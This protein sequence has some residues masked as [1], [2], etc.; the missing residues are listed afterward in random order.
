[1]KMKDHLLINVYV[2]TF[3]LALILFFPFGVDAAVSISEVAWMGSFNSANHE[4]IELH[5]DGEAI[6]VTGWSISDGMNLSIEFENDEEQ[7]VIPANSYVVLERTSDASALVNAFLIYTGALVNSGATLQ[8][9]RE[10]GSIVDQVS[11][12]ENWENIGGDNVTKE[13]AQYT[14]AGWVTATPTAGRGITTTEVSVAVTDEQTEKTTN[15]TTVSSLQKIKVDEPV[16]LTLPEVALKLEIKSQKVGYVHQSIQLLVEPSGIGDVLIDSLQYEWNFGDGNSSKGK[17]VAHI[18]NYPGTYVVTVY[19]GYKRQEQV[20]KTEITIL[21]VQI[22][23][24]MNTF[25]DVQVNNDSPYDIDISG[26]RINAEREFVFPPRTI[27]LSNQTI[28][29]P[30]KK[31]GDLKNQMI[32]IYDTESTM[33]FS[34]LPKSFDLLREEVIDLSPKPM[35]SAISHPPILSPQSGVSENFSFVNTVE[36]NSEDGGNKE[37][38]SEATPNET[39]EVSQLTNVGAESP[40]TNQYGTY[41][42]LIAFL[43]LAIVGVYATPRQ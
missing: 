35:I 13:T 26:Y 38:M 37:K 22:S 8:L 25:G 6:D 27:L 21:P 23:L 9:L 33:L 18:Y 30:Y 24:T 19:A 16:V 20:T 15:I 36:A 3:C 42:A 10:D 17:E 43:S 1:M 31:L 11:G 28:T 5:N 41:F 12:G 40:K 34:K 4:W 29:I 2:H 39:L 32:A 14:N 7:L